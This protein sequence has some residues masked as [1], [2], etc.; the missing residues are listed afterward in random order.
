MHFR[1]FPVVVCATKNVPLKWKF[2]PSVMILATT[3]SMILLQ[4]K[5]ELPLNGEVWS[6][7][8]T[9]FK[10]V[11]VQFLKERGFDVR[12]SLILNIFF[13]L[14]FSFSVTQESYLF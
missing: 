11:G 7:H 13:S 1:V 12:Q 2:D 5:A 14:Q 10:L 3:T 8:N 6:K 9:P 4:R